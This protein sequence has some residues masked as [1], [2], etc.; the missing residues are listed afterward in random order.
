M[1]KTV[2]LDQRRQCEIIAQ[3]WSYNLALR[4]EWDENRNRIRLEAN[5]KRGKVWDLQGRLDALGPSPITVPG[6]PVSA[7]AAVMAEAAMTIRRAQL[8]GKLSVARQ[9]LAKK[10]KELLHAEQQWSQFDR[11]VSESVNKW[12]ANGCEEVTPRPANS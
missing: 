3:Y 9:E 2:S 6:G 8:E 10:E 7:A 5:E 1:T 4:K 12:N 11:L